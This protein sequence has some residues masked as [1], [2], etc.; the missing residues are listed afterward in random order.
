METLFGL[1]LT[2]YFIDCSWMMG[3]F[4]NMKKISQ[5]VLPFCCMCQCVSVEKQHELA[6]FFTTLYLETFIIKLIVGLQSYWCLQYRSLLPTTTWSV[7]SDALVKK[8]ELKAPAEKRVL[9]SAD[10]KT[11]RSVDER[12][13]REAK[14]R[15]GRV[16]TLR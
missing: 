14:Q 7:P 15:K 12:Q 2:E 13:E 9:S 11:P 3:Y 1:L 6:Q 16:G 8:S 5:I 10:K 4:H